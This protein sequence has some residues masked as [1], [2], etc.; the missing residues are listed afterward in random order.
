MGA[1]GGSGPPPPRPSASPDGCWPPTLS[2]ATPEQPAAHLLE[3]APLHRAVLHLPEVHVAKVVCGL[4]LEGG[5]S[6]RPR[7]LLTSHPPPRTPTQAA[8]C[9]P[10]TG[11]CLGVTAPEGR[12]LPSRDISADTVV[13][14]SGAQEHRPLH[15]EPRPGA[16]VEH[17]KSPKD[18]GKSSEAL[19]HPQ[20]RLG[21][22]AWPAAVGDPAGWGWPGALK[23]RSHPPDPGLQGQGRSAGEA[24][25]L[26]CRDTGAPLSQC[27]SSVCQ[28]RLCPPH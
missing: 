8:A 27:L 9:S 6:A 15:T 23:G 24:A 19:A 22:R 17:R 16:H 5:V 14:G 2:G 28:G 25:R 26:T 13:S 7:P 21:C 11:I 10:Q 12:Q 18:P 1:P 3:V 20:S 4:P